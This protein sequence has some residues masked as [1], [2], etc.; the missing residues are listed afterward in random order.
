MTLQ[1]GSFREVNDFS[2]NSKIGVARIAFSASTLPQC[3]TV[4]VMS[5]FS[6]RKNKMS[7]FEM[8]QS[9]KLPVQRSWVVPCS[10]ILFLFCLVCSGCGSSDGLNRKAV[11]GKVTV[12]GVA[13]PNGSVSFEPLSK[14]GVGSGAV[15]TKGKYSI[16]KSDGLPP[17]KYRVQITGDDGTNFG[18]SAGKMPGD[19]EMPSR[20]QLVPA[21]W[22]SSSKQEIEVKA[23]GPF[24]FDFPI[25]TKKK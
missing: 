1:I 20:K 7:S 6:I 19:E 3:I 9:S 17:G 14:G 16:S 15:I 12:D 13:V 24:V 23:E 11:S 21:S 8:G 18:V 10:G 25:D 22:N 2:K 4:F 5:K